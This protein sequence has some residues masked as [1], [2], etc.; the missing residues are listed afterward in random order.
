MFV[1]VHWL[2]LT[3]LQ[4]SALLV[5]IGMGLYTI[6]TFG[7]K[8]RLIYRARTSSARFATVLLTEVRHQR[9]DKGIQ[10]AEVFQLQGSHLAG[11]VLEAL[12]ALNRC[13][14]IG[15]PDSSTLTV[16]R[17]VMEQDI[18]KRTH[19]WKEGLS[20]IDAI[21]RTAPFVGAAVGTPVAFSLGTLLA[22]SALWFATYVRNQSERVDVELRLAASEL[23]EYLTRQGNC[24]V[25]GK[26]SASM[27][28]GS[29]FT[30]AECCDTCNPGTDRKSQEVKH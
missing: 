26:T 10:V 15:S 21:G 25:C 19:E 2:R 17:E 18:A 22:I 9:V 12:R 23:R 1:S 8:A 11:L 14:S 27:H 13:R 3:W 28:F 6:I 4:K 24:S 16:V 20:F 29:S 5:L 7:L 30:C